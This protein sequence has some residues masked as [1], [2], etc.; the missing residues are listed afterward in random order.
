MSCNCEKPSKDTIRLLKEC[1][2]GCKMATD[3]ME[4]IAKYVSDNKLKSI[5]IKY[6][7]DH[8]KLEKDIHRALNNYG[9]EDQE[10]NPIAKASSWIQSEIK[11]MVNP[12]AHQAASL[13]IDGC[14]MGIKS[15]CEYK[16][17]Y[18]A[19]DEKSVQF[20]EKILALEEKMIEELKP[21]L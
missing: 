12:D 18:K 15:L 9:K 3:S 5:I 13:L 11:M 16:N 20:C 1:D 21:F 19:A 14:N 7:D 2:A 4:Q 10:P 17:M 6:N 8:I